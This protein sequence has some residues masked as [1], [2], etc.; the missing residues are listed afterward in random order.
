MYRQYRQSIDQK[1]K[2]GQQLP[3]QKKTNEGD[4]KNFHLRANVKKDT[5]SAKVDNA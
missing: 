2:G 3:E 5:V 4:L 1:A